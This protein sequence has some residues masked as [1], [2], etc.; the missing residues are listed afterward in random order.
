MDIYQEAVR[1]LGDN[2]Y[3]LDFG[4]SHVVWSDEN[5]GSAQWCLDNFDRYVGYMDE[6][7][8]TQEDLEVIKWS[9]R[10]LTKLPDEIIYAVPEDYD[11]ENPALYPP[12]EGMIV[13]RR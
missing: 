7:S 8:Y 5:W 12:P 4:P 10:E 6:D 1:R 13:I 9:L 11:D 3:L 2:E